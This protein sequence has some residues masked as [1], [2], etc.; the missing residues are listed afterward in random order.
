M[1]CLQQ[2]VLTSELAQRVGVIFAPAQGAPI[3]VPATLTAVDASLDLAILELSEPQAGLL[4]IQVRIISSH[5]GPA[6]PPVKGQRFKGSK[7]LNPCVHR[8][9]PELLFRAPPGAKACAMRAN[10]ALLDSS[11]QACGGALL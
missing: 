10:T 11:N 7:Y 6:L 5:A 8:P 1:L 4:P 3:R 2:L 9:S